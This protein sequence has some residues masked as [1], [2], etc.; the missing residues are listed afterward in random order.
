[1]WQRTITKLEVQGFERNLYIKLI[2]KLKRL[3]LL[4]PRRLHFSF[5]C[6]HSFTEYLLLSRW[7]IIQCHYTVAF[8]S[9]IPVC[10][11]RSFF[12]RCCS[13][14]WTGKKQPWKKSIADVSKTKSKKINLNK[15]GKWNL[16]FRV[17]SVP[18]VKDGER[19]G[20][21]APGS[22]RE[23]GWPQRQRGSEA[24]RICSEDSVVAT[25]GKA[26]ESLGCAAQ[27]HFWRLARLHSRR[28]CGL[29][30]WFNPFL[31]C[32]GL[33]FLFIFFLLVLSIGPWTKTVR[34]R[35]VFNHL[36]M[37]KHKSGPTTQNP[38][39]IYIYIYIYI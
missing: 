15:W 27:S 22:A 23:W 4:I 28:G 16:G 13:W 36:N 32:A 17:D 24:G 20:V 3:R 7:S 38:I 8:F 9:S 5:F 21:E 11:T 30:C 37:L 29:T 6:Y 10:S 18:N 1:M 12:R 2:Q 31:K 26:R 33:G 19:T 14:Q 25:F 34:P 39:Y 35:A